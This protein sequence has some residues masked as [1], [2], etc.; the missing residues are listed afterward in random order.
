[1]QLA[2]LQTFNEQSCFCVC[3]AAMLLLHCVSH[4]RL[5]ATGA[6]QMRHFRNKGENGRKLPDLLQTEPSAIASVKHPVVPSRVFS[7]FEIHQI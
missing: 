3:A 5:C 7:A 1:M 4:V 2:S 6:T